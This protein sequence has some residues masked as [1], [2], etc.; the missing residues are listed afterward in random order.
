MADGKV[1]TQQ[2]SV[3]RAVSLLRGVELGGEKS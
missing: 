1:Y 2:L 3:E